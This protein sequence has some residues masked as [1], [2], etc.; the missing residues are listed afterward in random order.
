M[1]TLTLLLAFFLSISF[2]Y[3]QFGDVFSNPDLAASGWAGDLNVFGVNTSEELQL[4]D[5]I[6]GVSS[7]YTAVN[8]SD[9][10]VWEFYFRLEFDPTTSNQLKIYLTSDVSD[11]SADVHGYFIQIGASGAGDALEVY[12]QDGNTDVL[13]FSGTAGAVASEP[14]VRVKVTRDDVGNWEMLVDYSGGMNFQSEGTFTD[15]TYTVGNFF[16]FQCKYSKTRSDLF[17][18]DDVYVDSS[19]VDAVPPV[20]L[21]AIALNANTVEVQFDEALDA[22]SA[23]N[24][25]NYNL[26]PSVA[27]NGAALNNDKVTLNVANLNS[28]QQYTLTV[29]NVKDLAGNSSG[30]QSTT[31]TYYNIQDAELHDIL[32]NEIMADPTASG[33][34]TNGLPD[35]EYIELY[36]R[37]AKTINLDGYTLSDKAKSLTLPNYI[38]LPGAYVTLYDE[39]VADFSSYGDVLPLPDFFGAWKHGR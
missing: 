17:Y 33:G 35:A 7:I 2:A 12:R 19:F 14:T 6:A 8:T 29:N 26:N 16:G 23:S 39:A 22:V 31:F 34:V 25:S 10:S 5:T 1:K 15:N 4:M 13:L 3:A 21:S 20:L 11:L 32:I 28:G 36:N 37:S 24:T 30:S 38:L 18:F 27:V 9:A